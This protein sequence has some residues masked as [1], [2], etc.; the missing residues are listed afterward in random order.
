MSR[1]QKDSLKALYLAKAGMN[2]AVSKIEKGEKWADNEEAFKRITLGGSENEFASVSYTL[3]DENNQPRT[4]YGAMDE[5]RKININN[6]AAVLLGSL[7]AQQGITSVSDLVNNILIW[8]GDAEAGNVYESL[9]YSPKKAP[10]TNVE[11]LALVKDIRPED[12]Q[13]LK[14]LV[15]VWADK[16]NINTASAEVLKIIFYSAVTSYNNAMGANVVSAADADSLV[17]QKILPFR[18]TPGNT[19]SDVSSIATTIDLSEKEGLVLEQAIQDDLI[20]AQS[21]YIRIES[22]GHVNNAAKRITAVFDRA[23]REVIFWHEN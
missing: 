8:R 7:L 13:K 4:V 20:T 1:Y 5:E 19:F 12:L 6:A 17:V 21:R 15:T 10:F 18:N 16:V 2:L 9:G 14:G 11:E 23:S 22:A 3:I